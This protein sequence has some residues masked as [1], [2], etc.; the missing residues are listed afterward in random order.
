LERLPFSGSLAPMSQ[1]LPI[2]IDD[3]VQIAWDV[4]ARSGE[5]TDAGDANYFLVGTIAKLATKGEHRRLMLI[6]RAIEDYRKH[7]Q[8]RAAS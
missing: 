8:A 7:K 6:N 3:A 1:P 2:L 4:L 5:I